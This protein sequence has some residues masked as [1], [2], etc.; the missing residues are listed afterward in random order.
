MAWVTKLGPCMAQVDYRLVEGAGCRPEHRGEFHIGTRGEPSVDAQISYRLADERALLWIGDG[1]AEVGITP[2]ATLRPEDHDAARAIMDGRHPGT[3]EVLVVPK[4]AVDPRAMLGGAALW[5]ALEKAAADRGLTEVGALL[6]G[7]AKAAKRAAQLERGVRRKGEAYVLP[8]EDA[9]KLAR[10]S[11]IDLA[12]VYDADQLAE[13]WRWRNARVRIGN[14]GYDLTL[15]MP[16]SVSVLYGLAD[17]QVSAVVDRVFAASVVETVAAVQGWVAY[18]QRGRQGDGHL[19]ERIATSGVLGWVMWHRTARP[20]DGAAP[21]PHLHAHAQIAN[22]VRGVDGKWSAVAAG[23]RDLYR[24]AH[25]AD[26]LL[27]AR[28]RRRVTE[29]LGARWDRDPVTG[30]WEIAGIGEQM[31]ARFSKRDGQVKAVLASRGMAYESAHSHAR[32][33]ASATSRQAKRDLAGG[34]LRADWHAQ[35]AADG[36]DA[37][38]ELAG[39]LHAG[40]GLPQRPSPA[41]IA[42]WIWREEGGLTAHTKIVSRADVLAAVADACPD[43][44]SGLADLEALTD[45]VLRHGPAV[46]LPDS[47]AAHLV[48][49]ARYSSADIVKAEQKALRITRSRYDQGVVVLDAATV[50]LAIDAFQVAGG[51]TFSLAQRQVLTRFLCAGHGVDALVG[52]AG[53][54]KTILMAAARG[55]WES[56]GLVVAGAATAAVAAA[57]LTAESGI[58]S[59]TI[60]AW[61]ARINDPGRPGL[62]GI[63]VLVVDEAAMVDDRALAILLREAE[64]TGTKV[65]LIG[66]PLQLRAVGVGGTFAAIHRQVEGLV[67]EENRRQVD[68]IERRALELWRAGDR[69]EAL[70]TWSQGGRVHA[71]QDA[72]D[73]LAALLADWQSARTPY[74]ADVHDELAAVLVLA[75]SN[76]DVE[77]LN[78]AARAIRRE[79]GELSGPDRLYR[80]PGGRTLAL[81]VGDHVRLRTNDYRARKSRGKNADVLNGY[82]GTVVAIHADRSVMVEWR[83]PGADG[84]ALVVEKVSAAYIASGG[85]SH[86]TAMTVA[87]AQGLTAEH[88]LV[89]GM[90]LDPHTLYAAMT[91]DRISAHL[92]LPRNVLESDADRARHGA[93]RNSAEELHRALD[94]YA[95]TLQGDRAD[96]LITPEPEPIAAVRAREREA[97]EQ[98]EVQVMAQAVFAAAMLE[99]VTDPRRPHGLLGDEQLQQRISAAATQTT[100]LAKVVE[101]EQRRERQQAEKVAA[102]RAQVHTELA[103][104]RD[105]LAAALTALDSAAHRHDAAQDRLEAARRKVTGLETMLRERYSGRIRGWLPSPERSRLTEQLQQAKEKLTSAARRAEA[106]GRA[107]QAV[108]RQAMEAF[109]AATTPAELHQRLRILDNPRTF[110]TALGKESAARLEAVLPGLAD[111]RRVQAARRTSVGVGDSPAD[112]YHR[113]RQALAALTVEADYRHQLDPARQRGEERARRDPAAP[114]LASSRREQ[115][116]QQAETRRRAREQQRGYRPPTPPGIT[117]KGPR[118]GYGR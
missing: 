14:R 51:F 7:N 8:Y 69:G 90:G 92:Y 113:A 53:A 42:A 48:N 17:P 95:A 29:E 102:V 117:A 83:R 15:D 64:R 40:G 18:G 43:G 44:V 89:Y 26:A 106:A 49:A 81:A 33:V 35:C 54:G 37:V 103:G 82:R 41:D 59:R 109:P 107:E 68:P 100:A 34:D 27:K 110:A 47:G 9:R 99:Q 66:D 79:S 94:A 72:S 39:C 25:P 85:L 11:G 21:D 96:H 118:Q 87:A 31:R 65:I 22:M 24:H 88:A 23:G 12:Q 74:R 115:A 16:K 19:A 77:R 70:H 97:A 32:R 4:K 28:V 75:G 6:G 57:N 52:V 60:A 30:A 76:A 45:A 98:A 5:Q 36:A 55:A 91:R 111:Q 71:G 73:T 1:L 61:V 93:P 2:G 46:R 56:R 3:G 86:G 116:Q 50:A 20:V 78:L 104:E 114:A 62:D 10:A 38:A 101:V 58:A 108:L 84:P 80:L 105:R 13:A 112:R 67:L 63:D